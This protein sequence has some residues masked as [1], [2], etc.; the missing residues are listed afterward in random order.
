[1]RLSKEHIK[2][3][4]HGRSDIT[5]SISYVMDGILFVE[6]IDSLEIGEA[7]TLYMK[8]MRRLFEIMGYKIILKNPFK[9]E[10]H[11]DITDGYLI[12]S[13]GEEID[14]KQ[15]N[16]RENTERQIYTSYNSAYTY[17][18]GKYQLAIISILMKEPLEYYN[19]LNGTK[20]KF[21]ETHH[22][23]VYVTESNDPSHSDMFRIWIKKLVNDKS[24]VRNWKLKQLGI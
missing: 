8:Y 6:K 18:N 19:E 1:M 17:H 10:K 2:N 11:K 7:N 24:F 4:L 15:S 16:G 5:N 22:G 9:S 23:G 3:Q 21:I 12:S 13:N 20:L 14:Y